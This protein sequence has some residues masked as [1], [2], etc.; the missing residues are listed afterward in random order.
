M[1]ILNSVAN[2]EGLSSSD[3]ED[4]LNV[5]N[6]LPTSPQLSDEHILESVVGQSS[7][8]DESSDDEEDEGQDEKIVSNSEAVECVKKCL[9]WMERQNNVDA[10]QIMQLRRM[11][12]L[13]MRTRSST[14]IQTD[15]LQHFRPI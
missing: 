13:S 7:F 9:S 6:E 14:L 12:E 5:E 4:W 11:M 8:E 1:D 15:L 10:I 2:R 3:V